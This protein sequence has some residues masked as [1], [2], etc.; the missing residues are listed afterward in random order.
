MEAILATF[1]SWWMF[2]L[3]VFSQWWLYTFIVPICAYLPFFFAKWI[4][5]TAPIW[6]PIHLMFN[7][8]VTIKNKI[9]KNQKEIEKQVN[10]NKTD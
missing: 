9:T 8:I 7:G 3:W 10:P 1:I 2:D 4:I 5:V 6:L